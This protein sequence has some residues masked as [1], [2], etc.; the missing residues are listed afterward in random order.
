MFRKKI[1]LLAFSVFLVLIFYFSI[2]LTAA[3]LGYR[4]IG[5]RDP[6]AKTKPPVMVV[7]EPENHTNYIGSTFN[8]SFN[9][10]T[11]KSLTA[12]KVSII[13]VYYTT[14]W[15]TNK[16]TLINSYT[17]EYNFITS[18]NSLSN[19]SSTLCLSEVPEGKHSLTV[20]A[21]EMGLYE[22]TDGPFWFDYFHM[23]V[24]A[25]IQF[26]NVNGSIEVLGVYVD[27]TP[28]PMISNLSLENTVYKSSTPIPLNYTVNEVVSAVKYSL[29]DK[30]NVTVAGNTVLVGLSGGR[31]SLTLY[32]I[33]EA[34]GKETSETVS[35]TVAAPA[36]FQIWLVAAVAVVVIVLVCLLVYFWKRR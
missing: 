23:N 31:H 30:E 13:R 15:L 24:S 21:I 36:S 27:T 33:D 8:V 1:K 19:Y 17:D 29:D 4:T 11:G 16:T 25:V 32:A 14:D 22:R 10:L 28:P 20:T 5:S 2:E 7:F 9:A 26:N 12:Y 3:Q 6:D 34:R 18:V 35:F